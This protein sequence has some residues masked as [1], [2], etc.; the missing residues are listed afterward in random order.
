MIDESAALADIA[1][2]LK[3][4]LSTVAFTG[5]GISTESGIADFRSPGG[6]WSRYKPV[7]YQDFLASHDARTRYW[8]MKKEGHAE[9]SGAEPN[10]AHRVLAELEAA[11]KL[12]AIVTQNIDGLHQDAGSEK[13]IELHGTGRW[14]ICLDC[15]RRYN[16]DKVFERMQADTDIEVPTCGDCD[17]IL[18]PATV[19]FGQELPA[20][21]IREAGEI[22]STCEVF[23]AIGSSLVVHPAAGLPTAAKQNGAYLVLINRDETPLDGLADQVIRTPIG[24]ALE[25]LGR[26]VLLG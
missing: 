4:S 7:Y 2:H 11:G 1:A 19:S 13:V 14:V 17:G 5:A 25:N 3:D 23:L 10:V 26:Q 21:V 8:K 15:P 6:V 18:K 9:F 20:D 12:R 16:A 22:S 24:A